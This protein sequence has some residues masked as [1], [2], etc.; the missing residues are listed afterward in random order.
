M[1]PVYVTAAAVNGND[2]GKKTADILDI[3]L[4]LKAGPLELSCF[5]HSPTYLVKQG[6]TV[7]DGFANRLKHHQGYGISPIRRTDLIQQR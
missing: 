1:P 4:Q 2:L 5:A 3:D 7:L 6:Y